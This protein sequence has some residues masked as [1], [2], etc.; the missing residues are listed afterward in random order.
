MSSSRAQTL[1]VDHAIG[2]PPQV[3]S[4][5]V[6]RVVDQGLPNSGRQ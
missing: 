5:E 6:Y 2:P 1:G 3:V 4:S